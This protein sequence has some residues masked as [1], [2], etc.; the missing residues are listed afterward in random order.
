ME[1]RKIG[2]WSFI[3]GVVIA[4]L[5]GLLAGQVEAGLLAVSLVILGLI[6]GLLNIS[7]KETTSFL[8]AAVTLV[9]VGAAG[10]EKLPA[11]GVFIGPVL[12]NIAT[13]VAPAAIIV[14]LKAVWDLAKK[15]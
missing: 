4:V 12:T 3:A 2:E 8:I 10:L 9:I 7:E 5:A 15:K 1:M 6:V 14:A 13:F 11:V